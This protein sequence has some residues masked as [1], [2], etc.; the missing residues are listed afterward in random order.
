MGVQGAPSAAATGAN[1]VIAQL[2]LIVERASPAGTDVPSQPSTAPRVALP[3]KTHVLVGLGAGLGIAVAGALALRV[4]SVSRERNA[5]P[6]VQASKTEAGPAQR[7]RRLALLPLR[8]TGSDSSARLVADGLTREMISSLTRA[9]V[10]VIGY[11]SVAAYTTAVVPLREVERVLGVNGIATGA[12]VR[13]GKSIELALEVANARTGETR[14]VQST[15]VDSTD[16][17]TLA[18]TAAGSLAGWILGNDA[19]S[20]RRLTAMP[21]VTPPEAY[22]TYLLAMRAAYRGTLV[23]MKQS[24]DLLESAIVRDSNFALAHAGLGM[25]LTIS[26]DYGI[27]PAD[28]AFR[29]AQPMIERAIALDSNL[30]LAHLARARLLQLRD[31]DWRAAEAEYLKAIDLEPNAQ[32]F[33]TY[34]WFLEWY[35]GRAEEGVAMGQR[36]VELDPGS[37]STRNALAWRLRGADQLERAATEAGIALELDPASID[38]YWILAEVFLRRGQ[39]AEAEQHARRY[40]RE[41]GDVPANSTTLGEILARSGR[42]SEANAFAS[43][44]ALLATRDGPSLVALARTEMALGHEERALTLLERAVRERV[45]TIPFQPYWDPIRDNPRFR[46]VMR[47]QGLSDRG[48][49]AARK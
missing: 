49:S 31:W 37:A 2:P 7:V 35:V 13:R 27:L 12:L 6:S 41:G 18:S 36:A 16:I 5:P 48:E 29:R 47:A 22:T 3:R 42:T 46:A 20:R 14:W 17:S 40:I 30:A 26:V 38:G 44:L 32:S 19:R 1:E 4:A 33:E 9:G 15:K 28:E 21:P 39:Y 11:R 10:A 24:I 45:F 8:S 23:T 34:G 43:R 25:A